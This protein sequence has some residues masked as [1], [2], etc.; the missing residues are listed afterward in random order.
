[1]QR[2]TPLGGRGG[3]RQA[4]GLRAGRSRPV[5]SGRRS[6]PGRRYALV[7]GNGC[8]GVVP[9]VNV[10]MSTDDAGG[11]LLQMVDPILSL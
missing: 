11:V 2:S 6:D 3:G 7:L 9:G 4:A 1:M 10:L 8:E 5:R